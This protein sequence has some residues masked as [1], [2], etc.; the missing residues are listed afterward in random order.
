MAGPGPGP[1]K[2]KPRAGGASG[3]LRRA[4]I[5]AALATSV[6]FLLL[7]GYLV[8]GQ[9]S[10]EHDPGRARSVRP[11]EPP[12][13]P[14]GEALRG[15]HRGARRG[16]GS[17]LGAGGASPAAGEAQGRR[18]RAGLPGRRSGRP[19]RR[20]GGGRGA[21]CRPSP[22]ASASRSG[23]R[24]GS[25]ERRRRPSP[26]WAPPGGPVPRSWSGSTRRCGPP[27][28]SS[29]AS[30]GSISSSSA[31]RISWARRSSLPGT[32]AA[33]VTDRGVVVARQPDALPDGQRGRARRLW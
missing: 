25:S 14:G 21:R 6:P 18:L 24:S 17:L 27:R 4:F 30:S 12:Q 9:V 31:P 22:R 20:A 28:D 3:S 8:W 1:A 29:G 32:V 10:R 26:S 15:A 11:G 2:G 23:T 19:V 13:R 16:R 7:I 5:G 33:L